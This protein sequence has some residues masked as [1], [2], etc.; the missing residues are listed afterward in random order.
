VGTEGGSFDFPISVP[1]RENL[2]FVNGVVYLT[3][4]G[5]W[6]DRTRAV[7]T[8]PIQ[9][10]INGPDS[11]SESF[12]PLRMHSVSA[13]S[14][15]FHRP[16]AFSRALL[17]LLLLA[18]TVL[19]WLPK[20]SCGPNSRWLRT[21]AVGLAL[22]CV[23]ELL[24]LE[25]WLG[26]RARALAKAEDVYYRRFGVQR[27]LSTAVIIATLVVIT[28]VTRVRRGSR[29]VIAAFVIYVGVSLL[30]L[31]SLHA[32]DRLGAISW[33]GLTLVRAVKLGCA[34]L[35]LMGLG[36]ARAARLPQGTSAPPIA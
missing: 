7:F 29:L 14:K 1:P 35:I 15:V 6:N 8:D 31:L 26:E 23:W 13:A 2:R 5:N 22:A 34:I 19:A 25:G 4:T 12:E 21:L 33:H 20:P 27:L 30:S 32:L 16:S 3:P 17:S 18:A 11:V 9:V 28:M 10:T 36:N 24:G